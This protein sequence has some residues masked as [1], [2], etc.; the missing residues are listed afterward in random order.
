MRAIRLLLCYLLV[1]IAVT[2]RGQVTN[3]RFEH[4]DITHGL[5]QSNVTCILQDSKGFMWFGT[6]DGLN[7]Y[8]GYNFTVF[9]HDPASKNSL[10]N[11]FVKGLAE[12]K[13]GNLWIATRGGGLTKLNTHTYQFSVYRKN[14]SDPNSLRSDLTTCVRTDDENNVW[15]GTED[16]GLVKLD[17]R[18]GKF[19]GV[20][21]FDASTQ[22]PRDYVSAIMFD[23]D[24]MLWIGTQYDGLYSV[25][26]RTGKKTHYKYDPRNKSGLLS[27]NVYTLFQDS[28]KNLWIGTVGGGLCRFSE[29]TSSFVHYRHNPLETSSIGNNVV[30]SISEDIDGNLWVG[31]ENGGI[32]ILD[33]STG[34]FHRYLQDDLDKLG[35]RNNSIY[36]IQR[37]SK[38][39]MWVGTFAEGICYLNRDANKFNHYRRNS[40]N[41]L[42][43]NKVLCIFE[44]SKQ[45]VWIGTDGGG[46]NMIDAKSGKFVHYQ[47]EKGNPN[48]ICGNY[49]LAVH[50]DSDGNIWIGTWGD[51]VS[52]FNPKTKRFRHFRHSPSDPTSL[53]ID[54]AWTIFEDKEQNVW[55]G[56]HGGGLN[57]F[58]KTTGKFKRYQHDAN[59]PTS[60]S[61]SHVHYL[62]EDSQG[63]LIVG[64][65]G[66]GLDIL[67]KKTGVF[68]HFANEAGKNSISSNSV[69][70][71]L[72][73]EMG[74]FWIGTRG[75]L[76]YYD[77][78]SRQFVVYNTTHGLP[79]NVVFGILND[80]HGNLWLSTS[81]GLSKFNIATKTFTNFT[82]S[83]GLQSNEF[84]ESAYFRG[85]T[86]VMYFG[87]N[88]GFNR[89]YPSDIK[90]IFFEPPLLLTSFQIFNKEVVIGDSSENSPLLKSITET[91]QITIPWSQSVISFEFATLNYT[92]KT[93]KKYAYKLEGFDTDWNYAGDR[94]S[95]TYTNLSAGNYKLFVKGLNNH[96]EWSSNAIELELVITPPFW[97]TWW[98]RMIGGLVII[99]SII[100]VYRFRMASMKAQKAKLEHMVS[101]RTEQLVI[102]SEQERKARTEAEEAN[103]A[104]SIFLA[105]MSHEIRT[106]M[107]GVIGMA[108]L[109]A[110]TP[111]NAQQ[112][113]YTETIR[114]CGETLL[115]VI[116]DIL[117][118]SK[119]E[120]GKMELDSHD[121]DLRA[122]IE[123]VLDVFA[124]KAAEVGIDL[125]Y[126]IDND[127]PL[128]IRGDGLRLKQILMNLV[129]NA[130]KFTKNGEIF[131]GV[132]LLQNP[133]GRKMRIGF[134]IRDTGIGI[135]P[136]KIGRLFKS[137]S[138]VDSST[139]RKYGGTGLGLAI[140]DKLVKLMGGNIAVQSRVGEGSTFTFNIMT[141]ASDQTLRT[142]VHYNMSGLENRRV[143]VLDDNQT[144]RNI[145]RG[146]LNQWKLQPVLASCGGDALKILREQ[147]NIDLIITDMQM[148]EMDG[149]EFATEVRKMDSEI[150]I[151][152][153]SSIADGFPPHEAALFT[154]IINKPTR[155][156]VLC[157]HILHALKPGALEEMSQ[158][159]AKEKL[160]SDFSDKH[161]LR[162]LVAEDNLINQKL[163]EH[164]LVKLGYQIRIAD[165]GEKVVKQL[166]EGDYDVVLMDVQMPEMDG[167]EATRIIRKKSLRQPVIIALTANAMQGDQEECFAAGMDDYLSKPVKIEELTEMLAKWYSK[168]KSGP[169]SS[170][171]FGMAI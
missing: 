20:D 157:K 5:S 139:T 88:N 95:V 96:G 135:P 145:L 11:D 61:G 109:L 73:D 10:S 103:K 110:E 90:H 169:A 53:A 150:P 68:T 4:L 74:N 1:L 83:D 9:K 39:N 128:Q 62:G 113:E 125:V 44:D 161:P 51:G 31:L 19:A 15:V 91:N 146:Q 168:T 92:D 159:N 18:T 7:R 112:R 167:L 40:G 170:S 75:G 71:V 28:Q 165:N 12:D 131:V 114:N 57:L 55:I 38:G 94:R 13:H 24:G 65:D 34:R 163:I 14:D 49:V 52:V 118:F 151:I 119:I 93:K 64:L 76:N 136:D 17:V 45:N 111:L 85:K 162:I 158:Q 6:R 149:V 152:L 142:Y 137:F 50:E 43:H 27:E 3:L 47:H 115:G 97:M 122:C 48:S 171:N 138:Q 116:N 32:S 133:K 25:N 66:T 67:D 121:I 29:S 41:S 80:E 130:V 147:K 100:G 78:L 21:L 8:D 87:G 56:T 54:H 141:L 126:Q 22:R 89:F 129:S 30:Y 37:D 42:S 120:S 2:A 46:V 77:R 72:E 160:P 86:G 148:P 59:S 16:A 105:T 58:D 81:N 164:I 33:K 69:N 35:L 36:D 156:N 23:A 107:N 144:N 143:L 98:F 26:R 70:S 101:E 166:E 123:E 102:L 154:A 108:S 117:D 155:Q 140:C 127:V 79:N 132:H 60:I 153:L 99:G 124:G 63:N 104:K 134:E 106:P 84:K 82:Q